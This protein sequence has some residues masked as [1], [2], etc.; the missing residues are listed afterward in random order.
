MSRYVIEMV[1]EWCDGVLKIDFDGRS[2]EA[3]LARV[4]EHSKRASLGST[5]Q[6]WTYGKKKTMTKG[7][8]PVSAILIATRHQWVAS[9]AWGA[10]LNRM[11]TETRRGT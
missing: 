11:D 1:P 2:E 6:Q 9:S 4:D 7:T 5:S 8:L 3:V 10:I